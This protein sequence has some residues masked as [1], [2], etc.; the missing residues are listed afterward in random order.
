MAPEVSNTSQVSSLENNLIFPRY[1]SGRIQF[2]LSKSVWIII[3]SAFLAYR[4]YTSA[5]LNAITLTEP[6]I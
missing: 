5:L 1:F 6:N 2:I 4:E 3:T